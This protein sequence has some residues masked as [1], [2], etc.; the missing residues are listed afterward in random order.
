MQAA[1]GLSQID[2]LEGFIAARNKNFEFLS[3]GLK[4]VPGLILPRAT[5]HSEPSWFGFPITLEAGLG[6]TR[7]QL[8]EHLDSLKIGTRLLFGGNLVRQ[9]AYKNVD[10]RVVSDL[11]NTDIVTERTF[12]V[13]VYPGLTEEMLQ[14]VVDTIR[15]FV[16]TKG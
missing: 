12:W 2:K 7:N 6:F 15:D 14:F 10:F 16:T 13:G 3:T 11:K 4:D 8:V 9:P 5:E 1:I